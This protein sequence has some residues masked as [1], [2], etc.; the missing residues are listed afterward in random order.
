[1]YKYIRIE[2]ISREIERVCV[3]VCVCLLNIIRWRK[4]EIGVLVLRLGGLYLG[5]LQGC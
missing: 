5:V 1:M 4:R 2:I 3:C